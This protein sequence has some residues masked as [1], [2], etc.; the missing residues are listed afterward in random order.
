MGKPKWSKD[1]I[2]AWGNGYKETIQ[3]VCDQCGANIK[4]DI[5]TKCPC[6]GEQIDNSD[7]L[8]NPK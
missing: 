3:Y 6:C 4:P 5:M 1:S 7:I 2:L 8:K